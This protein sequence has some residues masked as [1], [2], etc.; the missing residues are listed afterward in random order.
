MVKFLIS[1]RQNQ[2]GEKRAPR[3]GQRVDPGDESTGRP[4]AARES[5]W[6]IYVIF[7]ILVGH[8]WDINRIPK[9]PIEEFSNCLCG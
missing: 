2:L 8:E 7:G 6:D 1:L 9:F 5:H 3:S 4:E